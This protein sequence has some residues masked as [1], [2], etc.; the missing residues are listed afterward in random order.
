MT[1]R[2][3]TSDTIGLRPQL[4][5][6]LGVDTCARLSFDFGVA[7]LV[8][9][10]LGEKRVL[11]NGPPKKSNKMIRPTGPTYRLATSGAIGL[12]PELA[13]IDAFASLALRY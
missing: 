9:R 11:I 8:S 3:A 6:R 13:W 10:T 4:A 1:Y 12:R 5:C 7:D 2:L